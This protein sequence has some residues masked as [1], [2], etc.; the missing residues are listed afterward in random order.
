MQPWVRSIEK[1]LEGKSADLII[2]SSQSIAG[3][4][5]AERISAA[6]QVAIAKVGIG[7]VVPSGARVPITTVEEFTQA[8]L[9]AKTVVFA[10]PAGGGAAGIHIA[11]VLKKLGLAE[12]LQSKIK[13]GAGGDVTEV[14]LAQGDGTLG[15]TQISEIV[16]KPG[17]TLVGPLPEG[18]QNY[19][20][21]AAG[22][23]TGVARSEPVA[24]FIAFL[25]GPVA[26]AALKAKGMQ[27]D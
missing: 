22:T 16:G 26:V 8:V 14:T 21:V 5:K 3:L 13:F 19:T 2:G 27:V 17:A 20:G 6:S 24:A 15:M 4:V 25:R 18:L 12:V 7:I 9:G 1:V 23:L 10:N 11:E